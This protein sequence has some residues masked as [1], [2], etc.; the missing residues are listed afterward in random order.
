MTV[1]T[2]PNSPMIRPSTF[3]KTTTG[4]LNMSYGVLRYMPLEAY[5]NPSHGLRY[6]ERLDHFDT[7]RDHFVRTREH[8][9]PETTTG[10]PRIQEAIQRG[11]LFV[12]EAAAAGTDVRLRFDPK[13]PK[14]G[15][16]EI[17]IP[18]QPTETGA[19]EYVW[20]I[21]AKDLDG[22]WSSTLKPYAFRYV[23]ETLA[24]D[25]ARTH[26]VWLVGLTGF[27]SISEADDSEQPA[28]A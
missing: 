2:H 21:A 4:D 1:E 27:R 19:T 6:E 17:R 3:V 18:H 16:Y 28:E 8:G 22:G 26:K 25:R 14:S 5:Y 9:P 12:I 24:S 20:E 7:R 13:A 11:S 10:W 15:S 23:I